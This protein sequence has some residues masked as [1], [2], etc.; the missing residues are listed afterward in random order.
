[1]N[2]FITYHLVLNHFNIYTSIQAYF[3]PEEGGSNDVIYTRMKREKVPPEERRS[4][5]LFNTWKD[6]PPRD[7][8]LQP[9][10]GMMYGILFILLIDIY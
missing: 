2:L 1:M 10:K 3:N 5:L 7:I 9:P 4:V 6:T 8:S